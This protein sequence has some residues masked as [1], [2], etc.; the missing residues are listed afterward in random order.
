MSK[1]DKC[2][3]CKALFCCNP[4]CQECPDKELCALHVLCKNT[5]MS[6]QLDIKIRK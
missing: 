6:F 5:G 2:K 4:I 3:Q 1:K